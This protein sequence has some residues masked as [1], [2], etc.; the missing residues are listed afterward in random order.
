[1]KQ[2][3][4]QAAFAAKK[5][6]RE[7]LGYSYTM[8]I[9]VV[10]GVLADK[11]VSFHCG[12]V[13]VDGQGR[14]PTV[15]IYSP[16]RVQDPTE[17]FLLTDKVWATEEGKTITDAYPDP[18]E[19]VLPHWWRKMDAASNV[20]Q[21][22]TEEERQNPQRIARYVA[23]ENTAALW[24]IGDLIVAANFRAHGHGEMDIWGWLPDVDEAEE[25]TGG[26]NMDFGRE[27]DRIVQKLTNN[28][29]PKARL[30]GEL[31]KALKK[32]IGTEDEQI[33]FVN[34]LGNM[35]LDPVEVDQE[36]FKCDV[37]LE[38]QHLSP[39]STKAREHMGEFLAHFAMDAFAYRDGAVFQGMKKWL[40]GRY[41]EGF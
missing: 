24:G 7:D 33:E 4:E 9:R 14:K 39:L 37:Y 23:G 34:W 22:P 27:V 30:F 18:M 19:I 13:K 8:T 12:W 26:L 5:L 15:S 25:V 32:P 6:Y 35:L 20:E 36:T 16:D 29:T 17:N 28:Q 11:D 10:D 2:T 21:I 41:G 1:V 3:L 38:E 40:H 31:A